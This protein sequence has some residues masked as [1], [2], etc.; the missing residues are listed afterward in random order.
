M[1]DIMAVSRHRMGTDGKGVTTL[2]GFYGCPLNCRYCINKGCHAPHT[3]RA[4]YTAEELVQLLALDEPYFL[5][6][7]GGVAFGGG[8][9]L[10]QAEFIR[11]VCSEMDPA[12]KRTMETSLNVEW[13][14]VSLLLND[15]DYWYVDIKEVDPALYKEY[16]GCGNEQVLQ[17]LKRLIHAVGE[18][19]VCV[20]YPR[21]PGYNTRDERAAGIQWLRENI[22]KD[23]QIEQFDYIRC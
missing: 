21:I 16:T 12:W 2:V 9:P 8:E 17:N 11:E 20:R 13:N 19:K 3:A 18:D 4:S 14:A 22:S 15:I 7:G 10:M 1:S 5:M 23:I 6:S